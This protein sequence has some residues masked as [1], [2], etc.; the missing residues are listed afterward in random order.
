MSNPIHLF[1]YI[2]NILKRNNI[3]ILVQYSKLNV[4]I[5]WLLIIFAR[6]LQLRHNYPHFA[7]DKSKTRTNI[8]QRHTQKLN[9]NIW[10][11]LCNFRIHWNVQQNGIPKVSYHWKWD[12]FRISYFHLNNSHK[13]NIER[14]FFKYLSII[15]C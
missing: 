9:K 11:Y 3:Q 4:L 14:D 8:F 12:F 7:N 1:V 10:A 15:H 6:V 5:V 13:T 2:L